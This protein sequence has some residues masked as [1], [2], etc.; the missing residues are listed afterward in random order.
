MFTVHAIDGID[1][2]ATVRFEADTVNAA[3]AAL[4]R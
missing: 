2:S 4:R 1:L 3:G